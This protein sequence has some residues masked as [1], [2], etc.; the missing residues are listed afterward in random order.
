MLGAT[1]L[2]ATRYSKGVIMLQT[3]MFFLYFVVCFVLIVAA[4]ALLA[5]FIDGGYND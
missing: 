2:L 1:K 5:E 3:C 4:C